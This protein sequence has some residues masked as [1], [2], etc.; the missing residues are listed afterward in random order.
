MSENFLLFPVPHNCSRSWLAGPRQRL[1]SKEL[2]AGLLS[3]RDP[4]PVEIVNSEGGSDVVLSCEHAGRAIPQRLG[5]LGVLPADMER[6]IAW[7]VGAAEVSRFLSALLDAPLVL[8]C[9]SRLVVDCNR[10]F[11]AGDCFPAV[12]DGTKVPGN[13]GLRECDRR[14]RFEEIHQ[15]FHR[16]LAGI[17]DR[18]RG[19]R[20]FLVSVHSFTPRLMGGAE[21]PWHMG[22]LFNRDSRLA[23]RFL[24]EFRSRNP[25]ILAASN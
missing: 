18:R 7:D 2:P 17:L 23:N 9:Y 15:P 5:D 22:V 21:R 14:Q 13:E 1:H 25:G 8:Q 12:S 4:P 24:R 6:H 20:T 16:A 19:R 3:P 11:D 10:P